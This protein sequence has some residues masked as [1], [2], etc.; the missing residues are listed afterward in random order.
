MRAIFQSYYNFISSYNLLNLNIRTYISL[1]YR[2]VLMANLKL[3]S[4]SGQNCRADLILFLNQLIA[5]KKPFI[6][7]FA[8]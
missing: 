3:D 5:F 8:F 4:L 1:N 6:K 2:E 7:L